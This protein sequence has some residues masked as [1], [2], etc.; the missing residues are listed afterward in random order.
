MQPGFFLEGKE[1]DWR[2][3]T[4]WVEGSPERSVWTGI[5]IKGRQVLPVTVYRCEQC[6]FL[7]SYAGPP[8]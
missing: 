7:E 1:G 5:K 3:L 4:E 6:G 8:V 2:S